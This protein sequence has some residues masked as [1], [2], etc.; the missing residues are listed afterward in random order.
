M[1]EIMQH[2]LKLQALELNES[3]DADTERRISLLRAKIP[4]QLIGHYDRLRSRGKKGLAAVR[5]EVCTACHM[6]VP[7]GSILTLMHREDIQVCENCGR[8]IYLTDDV[9]AGML[10]AA[11]MTEKAGA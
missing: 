6:H 10:G 4:T 8:Y 7:R 1:I 2:L 9:I 11:E 5:N 3:D